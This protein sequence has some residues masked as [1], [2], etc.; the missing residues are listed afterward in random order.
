[1]GRSIFVGSLTGFALGAIIG[2]ASYEK[3][4]CSPDAFICIGPGPRVMGGG[5]IGLGTGAL[6]STIVGATKIKIPIKGSLNSIRQ[7][8]EE[9]RKYM[10]SD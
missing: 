1:M 7:Q 3:T 10:I 2:F 4:E 9:L 8:Q 6:I 5:L